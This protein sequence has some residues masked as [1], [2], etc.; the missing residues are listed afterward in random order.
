MLNKNELERTYNKEKEEIS[1]EKKDTISKLLE[2]EQDFIII[3]KKI[4]DFEFDDLFPKIL[5]LPKIDF[6][7]QLTS[8]VTYILA[9]R[10]SNTILENEKCL[11]LITSTCHSFDKKYNK[12]IEELSQGW[13]KYNLDKI[14]LLENDDN[15]ENKEENPFFFINFRKHCHKTQN[16]AIHLCNKNG[17]TGK[18]IIIYNNPSLNQNKENNN[19]TNSK[20]R[21]KYLICDSCRKSYFTQEFPN[22]CQY[23]NLTYLCSSLYKN[24]DPNFLSATLNPQHCETFVNEEIP[25]DKCKNILYIDI[26]NS[27]LKCGNNSCDFCIDLIKNDNK[28]NFKCK[29]CKNDFYTNVRIY[30]PIEVFHFKDIVSK[31]L[32]YK[33]KAFPGKL[34]CCNEIKEKHTEFYH[35][36]DCK[37][38]LYFAEYNKKV[39]IVCSKCKAVNQ[40]SK[41]IWT[42]PECGIH[43]RDKKSEINEIK[44][45]KT[46]SSN[47]I[48]R[49]NKIVQEIDNNNANY[50]QA[51]H[52]NK[53]AIIFSSL[54]Q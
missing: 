29:I 46:K 10:F 17:E 18:F 30:N 54:S 40:Y 31:A 38:N 15:T 51:Y 48:N 41:F 44:I 50:H 3:I 42:C 20:P 8:N 21:I 1:E 43:F 26:K 4:I 6:L 37:G 36:K 49:L 16:I 12:Y 11:S 22:F 52:L 32:L 39:I 34:S 25:C 24:E 33:R 47:R 35:K 27:L 9:E 45:R 5:N 53:L 28:I 23:C 13:D 14:N 2:N 19:D 7:N